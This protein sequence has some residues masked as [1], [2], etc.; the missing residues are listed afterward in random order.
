MTRA[1]E[2]SVVIVVLESARRL[3]DCL[4]AFARQTEAPPFEIIVPWDGTHGL[5]SAIQS[6]FP[7][8]RFLP[9]EGRRTYAELRAAG[10][11]VAT[12]PVVAIT[13]DHCLPREDWCAAIVAAHA[14]A[15]AAIG[16]S[17]EKETPDTALNWAFY[18]AD[19]I[20]Y[21]DPVEGASHHLTD[22]N[23]AYKRSDLDAVAEVWQ[24]EFHENQ[25]HQA[26][27]SGG[28]SLWLSPRIV[29][30]QKRHL[31]WRAALWDRY[32]F[33]RLFASTR[34][35]GAPF[36][37]RLLMLASCSI[38]PFLLVARVARHVERTRRYRSNFLAALP[39][40]GAVC[41]VWAWGEFVGYLTGSP[42]STLRQE[43]QEASS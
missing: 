16:G 26:L 2:L 42:E 13:E 38:L 30:R 22:C 32:A 29:V 31:T 14:A 9:M 17:V 19:Y 33:G 3:E 25:V 41:T 43:P 10:I 21:L 27:A 20:R 34:V 8:V 15:H 1:I 39:A 11:R 7:M 28:K 4:A 36:S 35:Q 18:F 40:V 37:R 12:A 5:M 24:R 6:L 23:V